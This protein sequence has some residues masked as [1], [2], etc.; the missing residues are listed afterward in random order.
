VASPLGGHHPKF[1]RHRPA[2]QDRLRDQS[3][4]LQEELGQIEWHGEQ[5]YHTPAHN[6]LAS[7]AIFDKL[8]PLLP[9]DSEEVNLKIRQ[10][11]AMLDTT[12]MTDLTLNPGGERQ[13]QDPDHHQN[14][15]GDSASSVSTS[16]L[17][18]GQG[19]GKGDLWDVLR[20]KDAHA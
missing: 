5:V 3:Q 19:Q 14:P 18:H 10:L 1:N 20:T 2:G 13:G 11:H 4:T 12:M 6:A 15:H 9:K 8:T 7:R 17:E 16:R